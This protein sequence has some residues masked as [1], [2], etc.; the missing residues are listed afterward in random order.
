MKNVDTR[1]KKTSLEIN[2]KLR[3]VTMEMFTGSLLLD[4]VPVPGSLTGVCLC[5]TTKI[6]P[7]KVETANGLSFGH[8]PI[9]AAR[10]Q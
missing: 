4:A 7:S 3:L 5:Y 1:F 2:R 8:I 10:K 6:H 9:L